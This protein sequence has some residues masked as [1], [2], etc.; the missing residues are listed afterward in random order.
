VFYAGSTFGD[1]LRTGHH[2]IAREGIEA[3]ARMQLGA[4]SEHQ[5]HGRVG[6]DVRTQSG[7]FVCGH[8]T[9]GHRVWLLPGVVLTNDP[10]PPSD[11]EIGPTI[12]DDAVVCAGALILPQVRIG[13][14]AVVGAG[15]VV[16]RD[17]AS[18]RLVVG[19]PARDRGEASQIRHRSDGE[20]AYP[21]HRH[22]HRGYPDDL[23]RRWRRR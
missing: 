6:D 11:I 12:E 17:V 18:G 10:H 2:A 14:G 7:V 20:P 1:G 21:W 3:G 13:A 19:Q 22:F 5:G 8:V 16:T 23:V 9:L 4:R 15:S